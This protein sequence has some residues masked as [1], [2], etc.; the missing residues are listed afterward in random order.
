LHFEDC[1]SRRVLAVK[2]IILQRIDESG[3]FWLPAGVTFEMVD[4]ILLNGVPVES[5]KYAVVDNGTGIDVFE[6]D[7]YAVVSVILK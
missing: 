2:V 7:S 6:S 1:S 4:M 5:G 3:I